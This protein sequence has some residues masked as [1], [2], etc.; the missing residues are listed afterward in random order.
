MAQFTASTDPLSNLTWQ[1]SEQLPSVQS[2]EYNGNRLM[3]IDIG[4]HYA[5]YINGERRAIAPNFPQVVTKLREQVDQF[6]ATTA[7]RSSGDIRTIDFAADNFTPANDK[8]YL[9]MRAGCRAGERL[10]RRHNLRDI[11]KMLV[12]VGA[13]ALFVLTM[14]YWFEI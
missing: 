11:I 10:A 8:R 14:R 4:G 5:G 6:I 1:T 2:T 7:Y 13:I 9:A 3:V 12:L